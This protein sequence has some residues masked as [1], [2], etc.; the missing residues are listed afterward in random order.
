M[1]CFLW[2]ENPKTKD[3]GDKKMIKNI[4]L[5]GLLLLF[6]S[7]FYRCASSTDD[8][9]VPIKRQDGSYYYRVNNERIW[10]HP[11]VREKSLSGHHRS[12]GIHQGK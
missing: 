1:G 5:F 12:G 2:E 4:I 6:G 3:L 10:L 11:S 8:I 7:C 9:M